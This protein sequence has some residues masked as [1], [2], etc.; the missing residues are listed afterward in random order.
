MTHKSDEKLRKLQ[1]HVVEEVLEGLNSFMA[2]TALKGKTTETKAMA[3]KLIKK[4][5]RKQKM[6]EDFHKEKRRN[7]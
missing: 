6:L 4:I 3:H 7:D 1:M 2:H 5:M